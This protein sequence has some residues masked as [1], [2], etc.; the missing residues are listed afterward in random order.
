M[1]DEPISREY[2]VEY[3]KSDRSKCKNCFQPIKKDTPR[4]GKLTVSEKFDGEF[5]IW[6]H[7]KCFFAKLA[8]EHVKT[9]IIKKFAELKWADQQK[10]KALAG[11]E[12]EAI[13]KE[14]K[15]EDE[16]L[17]DATF[18]VDYAKSGKSTCR[19]CNIK[20]ENKALRIGVEIN[21]TT[22]WHHFTCFKIPVS[23][24]E[25]KDIS[26]IDEIE[27]E[28]KKAI[29]KKIKDAEAE[30]KKKITEK[31]SSSEKVESSEDKLE[32]QKIWELKEELKKLSKNELKE[33]LNL[34]NQPDTGGI[35]DLISR[36]ADGIL[37]GKIPPCPQCNN[38][39]GHLHYEDGKYICHGNISAWTK[40]TFNVDF[41]KRGNFELPDDLNLK[42]LKKKEV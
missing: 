17:D 25:V 3:A 34:N 32:N 19:T 38:S 18:T 39:G 29:E 8:S 37:N 2:Q 10:I 27:E 24:T 31:T 41:I 40:C 33:I 13:K 21:K 23:L 9:D 5:F 26:N 15:T 7:P 36:V 12:A 22:L 35:P 30:N 28:D 20:I 14:E 11:E 4:L 1:T 6:Y 42:T 16:K